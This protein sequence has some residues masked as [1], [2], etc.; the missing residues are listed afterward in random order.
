MDLI[1]WSL[2]EVSGRAAPPSDARKDGMKGRSPEGKAQDELQRV[3]RQWGSGLAEPSKQQL[4][5]C[6]TG[7]MATHPGRHAHPRLNPLSLSLSLS[8]RCAALQF[9]PL[10]ELRTEFMTCVS[11][12]CTRVVPCNR[13][14]P[15]PPP[16]LRAYLLFLAPPC[17]VLHF[18][19]VFGS[20]DDSLIAP[21]E[22][23]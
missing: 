16:P 17:P 12:F 10:F 3:A 8:L 19:R 20:T 21:P 15:P 7:F 4:A 23:A 1:L 6:L 11:S 2:E 18:P 14:F 22:I 9:H 13:L 5:E